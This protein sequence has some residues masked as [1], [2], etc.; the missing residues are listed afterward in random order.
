VSGVVLAATPEARS[1]ARAKVRENVE[2]LVRTEGKNLNAILRE[3]ETMRTRLLAMLATGTEFDQA[4]AR[5]MIQEV[6][7]ESVRL[8]STLRA[9]LERSY[10]EAANLGDMDAAE[11]VREVLPQMDGFRIST[12]VSLDLIDAATGRSADLVG[13]ISEAART[14][15]NALMRRSATGS[16][17]AADVATAIGEVLSKEGRPTG[18]FGTLATQTERVHR[19]ET[20]ALYEVAG[21]ARTRQIAEQS[22]WVIQEVWITILDNRTRDSHRDMNGATITVGESFNFG[23]GPTWSKVSHEQAQRDGGTIGLA[24][25]GPHDAI[26]PA[27][28]AVN[29]R[30]T[31]GIRRGP[32]K[33]GR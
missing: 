26:L 29:C 14:R 1:V 27:E 25:M 7:R 22:P 24:V 21:K 12:G 10:R 15:L 33:E 4:R 3:L 2:R 5:E 18:V 30:C 19:T 8:R 11:N 20:H 17:R 13:D 23:A 32:R 28:E 16:N 9:P 6:E 31:R